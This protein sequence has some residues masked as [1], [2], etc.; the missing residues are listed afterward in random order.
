MCCCCVLLCVCA[1]SPLSARPPLRRTTLFVTALP[2]DQFHRTPLC[3]STVCVLVLPRP[4]SPDRPSATPPKDRPSAGQ[5]KRFFFPFPPPFSS[6]CV[7]LGVFSFNFGG[8]LEGRNHQMCTFG[9]LG[10]SCDTRPGRW[11][12][13]TTARELQTCTFQ[14]PCASKTT[15]KFHEKTPKRE[16]KERKLWREREKKARNFGPPPF[17]APPLGAPLF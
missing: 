3:V 5:P 11:G 9:V 15:P 6:F 14:G 10:L 1:F 16:K 2:Q 17:G 8:V 13:H 7:S 4:S 12:S